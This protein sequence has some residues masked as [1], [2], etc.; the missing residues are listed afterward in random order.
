MHAGT[1]APRATVP[2]GQRTNF[3]RIFEQ[4]CGGR[5]PLCDRCSF[6]PRVQKVF[7]S[8]TSEFRTQSF[9]LFE[10]IGFGKIT[11][12]S[13]ILFARR[14]APMPKLRRPRHTARTL[15]PHQRP[16]SSSMC[17]SLQGIRVVTAAK[18][19][20]TNSL[21]TNSLRTEVRAAH[22]TPQFSSAASEILRDFS[23]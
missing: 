10:I 14:K 11:V 16:H 4:G 22:I 20:W 8:F 13:V 1:L 23:Q 12:P 5:A 7:R 6:L 21:R 17:R 3:E 2:T 19:H 9:G 15:S 18:V